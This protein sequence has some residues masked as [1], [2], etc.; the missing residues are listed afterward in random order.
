MLMNVLMAPT[1]AMQMR[2]AQTLKDR[3]HVSAILDMTAMELSAL[4]RS[5]IVIHLH[6][7][8]MAYA[9]M[10]MVNL[11]VNALMVTRELIVHKVYYNYIL[12]I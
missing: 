2:S 8:I 9:L 6:V 4:T 12:S 7:R 11:F 3:F 5:M 1:I 10:E